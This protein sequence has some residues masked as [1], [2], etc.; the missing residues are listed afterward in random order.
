MM[1]IA[2]WNAF[3]LYRK[4]KK[5]N[6]CLYSY[7]NYRDELIEEMIGLDKNLKGS[8]LINTSSIHDNRRFRPT[9]TCS[10]NVPA[11]GRNE[12]HGHWPEQMH[13]RPGTTKKFA[14]LK[15]KLCTQKKIRKETSYRCKGCPDKAPLCPSCFEPYH[16][17]LLNPNND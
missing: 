7:L 16:A 6:S 1:D 10:T 11:T 17:S 15:C 5:N 4:Y 12:M 9:T 14:F 3:F 8:D 13:A 2:V